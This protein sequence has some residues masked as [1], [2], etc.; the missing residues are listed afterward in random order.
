MRNIWRVNGISHLERA[1]AVYSIYIGFSF[2][3]L[4]FDCVGFHALSAGPATKT[5]TN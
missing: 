3:L 2:A 5:N 4:Y 1:N